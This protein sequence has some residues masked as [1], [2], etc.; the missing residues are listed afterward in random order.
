MLLLALG[1][2]G[3]APTFEN[4]MNAVLMEKLESGAARTRPERAM[5]DKASSSEAIRKYLHDRGIQCVIPE[6]EGQNANRLRKGS[7]GGQLVSYD[8]K[9]YKRHHVECSFNSLKQWRSLATRYDKLAVSY[10]AG[11]VMYAVLVWSAALTQ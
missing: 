7:V 8:K 6:K 9:A 5:A 10:R 1:P 2:A 11:A 4:L 3:D